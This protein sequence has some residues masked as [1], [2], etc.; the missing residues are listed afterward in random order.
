[1]AGITA[2]WS[3]LYLTLTSVTDGEHSIGQTVELVWRSINRGLVPAIVGGPWSWERWNPSPPMAT[4]PW[5]LIAAGWLV[6]V[7]AVAYAVRTRRGAAWIVAAAAGY[8]SVL[9][10]PLLWSRTSEF[11]ALELTQTLRYLPDSALVLAIAMALIVVAP[12]RPGDTGDRAMALERRWNSVMVAVVSVAF[13]VSSLISTLRFAD[14]WRD[15]PTADYLANARISLAQTR[16]TPMI[17]HPVPVAVLL[18]VAFPDNMVGRV[19]AGLDQ[20]PRF[21]RWTDKL[22]LLDD[23]GRLVTG[24]VTPT[25]TFAHADGACDRPEVTGPTSI[26]LSGPLINWDW[27]V[28]LPYCANIDGTLHIGLP[29]SAGLDVPVKAGLHTVYVRIDGA[30]AEVQLRPVTPGLYLHVGQGR[31]G[32]LVRAR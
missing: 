25:R 4:A 8:V 29:G 10:I 19:F 14:E 23:D 2:V 26:P 9:Q 27:T 18:P 3:I 31:V 7:A 13:I 5:W 28:A 30:G 17:D 32:E 24:D 1:M 15:N 21:G 16:D 22:Q 11:T 20:R 12:R 6:A